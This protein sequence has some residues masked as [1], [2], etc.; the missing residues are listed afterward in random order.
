VSGGTTQAIITFVVGGGFAAL[1]TQGVKVWKSLSLGARATTRAVV[2]DL[3]DARGEA[4]ARL[5]HERRVSEYWRA[6]AGNYSFQLRAA[7][8]VPDPE[9]PIPPEMV[10]R[11]NAKARRELSEIEDTL[12][13]LRRDDR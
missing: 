3:A 2:R 5:E 9:N 8:E 4:E 10:V 13:N 12:T 6:V 1:I 11:G 7:G